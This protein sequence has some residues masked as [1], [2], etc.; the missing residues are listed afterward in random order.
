MTRKHYVNNEKFL[1]QMKEFRDKVKT[2]KESGTQ[3]PRV[4]EYIGEC[5]FKIASHLARK[6]NFANYTFK[7]DMI[8]DGVENCL[9]YI[10]NFDPD[11]SSNPFAYFTQII[12]FAFLRRIQKEKKQL[13][14]KYKTMENE[15][16]N[17]LIENNGEDLVAGHLNGILHDSYSEEF[18]RDFINTFEDNKRRK[19]RKRKTKLEEFMEDDDAN[20]I[21]SAS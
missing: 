17:S 21:A 7:D 13:Y 1:E 6:P 16:I 9:L 18:I 5:V 8:S 20:A 10:D 2:A 4:P 19:I 12:Y 11:K 15:V 3:R 14:V